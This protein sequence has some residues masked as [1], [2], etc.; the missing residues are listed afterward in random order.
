MPTLFTFHY[1][2]ILIGIR[3]KQA[4][5][6]NPFTFHYGS[7]LIAGGAVPTDRRVDLHSTMVLF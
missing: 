4:G 2:S 1:G 3:V 7:I 6:S 5:E